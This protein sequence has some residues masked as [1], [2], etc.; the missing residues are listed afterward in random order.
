MTTMLHGH[1]AKL[2]KQNF[3][4]F[5]T[6]L[7]VIALGTG[8]AAWYFNRIGDERDSR[9]CPMAGPV[10]LTAIIID[11]TD[12]LPL[13]TISDVR[14]ELT[15]LLKREVADDEGVEV[16]R[17]SGPH[18]Q[19]KPDVPLVC[20]PIQPDNPFTGNKRMAQRRFDEQYM[21]PLM[22]GIEKALAAP[23]E[24]RSAI[25]ETVQAALTSLLAQADGDAPRRLRIGI[26]T[27]L[28]EHAAFSLEGGVPS[29]DRFITSPVYRTVSPGDLTG[30][31]VV[32]Y[33]IA[34][35]RHHADSDALQEFW[36]SLVQAQNG[37]FEVRPVIGQ[38]AQ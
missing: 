3:V 30:V 11:A 32:V 20:R 9:N 37:T 21:A 26:V 17:V 25:L 7:A 18:G 24:N 27:D 15:A 1:K 33:H 8:V 34:R 29:F 13:N 22:A 10:A 12:E 19:S 14:R 38:G 4:A 28:A 23:A 35:L 6:L 31:H 36:R 2:R 5:I 16:W